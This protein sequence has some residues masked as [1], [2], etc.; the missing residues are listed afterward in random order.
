MSK[1][2]TLRVKSF[3]KGFIR[4]GK[5]KKSHKTVYICENG[6]ER[7]GVPIHLIK[8]Y[9]FYIPF[10]PSNIHDAASDWKKKSSYEIVIFKR[11]ITKKKTSATLIV[12]TRVSKIKAFIFYNLCIVQKL[13]FG[14]IFCV[15]N[16]YIDARV[17]Q[18]ILCDH[19]KVILLVFVN[20]KNTLS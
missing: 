12:C 16:L 7:G 9:I 17:F 5:P 13:K 3:W 2:L 6:G 19:T 14:R 11:T 4:P 8:V 1:F 10:G 18:Q 20:G 15:L